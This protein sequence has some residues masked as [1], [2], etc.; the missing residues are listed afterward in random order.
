MT[1]ELNAMC[2][3]KRVLIGG[4]YCT[5]CCVNGVFLPSRIAV[6]QGFA[7]FRVGGP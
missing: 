5:I 2:L 3:S 7:S 1:A 4:Y 6:I